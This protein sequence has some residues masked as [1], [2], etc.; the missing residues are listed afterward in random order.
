MERD[1]K[2]RE[3]LILARNEQFRTPGI[4]RMRANEYDRKLKEAR[5]KVGVK[6]NTDL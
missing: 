5:Q 6:V 2:V 3:A 4:T 1:K